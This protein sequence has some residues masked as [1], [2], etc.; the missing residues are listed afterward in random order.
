MHNSSRDKAH[1]FVFLDSPCGV[2][3]SVS[4]VFPVLYVLESQFYYHKHYN[5]AYL[6]LECDQLVPLPL[7]YAL[8][9]GVELNEDVDDK[10]PRMGFE[11]APSCYQAGELTNIIHLFKYI[12]MYITNVKKKFRKQIL[13]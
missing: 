2:F 4:P 6:C 5:S 3:L 9:H 12:P 8:G 1:N 13:C 11:P 10:I 7:K